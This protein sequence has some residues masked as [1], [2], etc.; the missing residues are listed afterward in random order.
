VRNPKHEIRNPKSEKKTDRPASDFVLRISDFGFRISDMGPLIILSGPS[1][2]GKSTVIQ[3]LLDASNLPLRL[4]VSVTT[5]PQRK[6][7][8]EGEDYY[9]RDRQQFE[10]ALARNEFLEWAEV[11]G[12]RYGTLR[13][14]VESKRQDGQGVLLDIDVQGA[15]QV[16]K[17][18][19]DSVSIFLAPPSLSVLE[20]RLRRRGTED[21]AAIQRRLVAAAAEMARQDEY[22]YVV[23]ND[24]LDRAVA[25]V[26]A[27][28]R[29]FF[30][31]TPC[32]TN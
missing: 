28:L 11:Y 12:N 30:R 13:A 17:A 24:N 29:Q 25:D 27:W 26:E 10:E 15:E 32:S 4:S 2:S 16:R 21:E 22:D 19:P 23:I 14:E 5:R 9:F 6:N 7:E 20:R 18:C 31:G 1:G 8:N 3:R